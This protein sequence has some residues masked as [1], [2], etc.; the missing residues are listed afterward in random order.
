[1][2]AVVLPFPLGWTSYPLGSNSSLG[3]EGIC[4]LKGQGHHLR[5]LHSNH[6]HPTPWSALLLDLN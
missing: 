3:N 2:G 4:C 5:E 6:R 1:M